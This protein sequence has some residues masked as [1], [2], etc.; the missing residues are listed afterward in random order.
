MQ[1]KFQTKEESK[2]AQLKAFLSLTPSERVDA[3][4]QLMERLKSF[5]TQVE[6]KKNNFLIMIND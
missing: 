2:E 1:I 3:F 4:F 5:P 6:E